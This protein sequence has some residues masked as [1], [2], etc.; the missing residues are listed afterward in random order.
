MSKPKPK[1]KTGGLK[2]VGPHQ[3][4]G[5]KGNATFTVKATGYTGSQNITSQRD[6]DQHPPFI[7]IHG[8]W[9]V[10]ANGDTWRKV[11]GTWKHWT[12]RDS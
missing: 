6:S 11:S 2:R 10:T 1:S 12:V 5:G 3:L 7:R 4:L 8:T 9:A